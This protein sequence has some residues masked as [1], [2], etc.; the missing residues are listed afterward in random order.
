MKNYQVQEIQLQSVR[1]D[2]I[3]GL[4]QEDDDFKEAY[5]VCKEM[6]SKYHSDFVDYML[7]EG[8][9]F[10][11]TQ[12]CIPRGLIKDNVVKEKHGGGLAGYFGLDKT[13]ELVK[14]FYYWP[15]M[16]TNVG[17]YVESCMIFQQENGKSSN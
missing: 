10:K 4:Y 9:L 16:Q 13:L 1:L 3:K 2:Q 8:F 17:R 6:T 5:Q 7:Q 15:K 12:I 14:R 11:G